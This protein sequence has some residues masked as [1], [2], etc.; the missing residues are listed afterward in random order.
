MLEACN[1]GDCLLFKWKAIVL[2][3]LILASSVFAQPAP[4]AG[5]ADFFRSIVGDWVGTYEHSVNGEQAED[6]YF[7]F[8]VKQADQ[9]TFAS[10][11]EYYRLDPATGAP[12]PAG[13]AKIQ[14]M[15]QP[16]GSVKCITTGE[17]TILVEAKPKAQT[18]NLLETLCGSD[19]GITGKIG[20]K[21][22]VSGLPLG[23][24]KNGRVSSGS[25]AWTLDG[26]TL[27]IKQSLKTAFKVL[28]FSKSYS[29]SASSTATR[30]TDLAGLMKKARIAEKPAET[31]PGG[32]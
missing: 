3:I 21:V 26:D 4:S 30:G 15:V 19:C 22:S 13:T 5:A 12:Q 17:G 14:T 7:K 1:L 8:S 24:G 25:S 11:F 31:I 10:H 16:D 9:N 23:L 18:Y 6:T 27:T 20:G 32:S 28:L 29:L 2:A